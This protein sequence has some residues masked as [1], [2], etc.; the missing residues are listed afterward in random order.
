MQLKI[1]TSILAINE[2]KGSSS[3]SDD[4]EELS[5][6]GWYSHSFEDFFNSASSS[7]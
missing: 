4:D 6:A 7:K 2:S 5:D 3:S 1:C